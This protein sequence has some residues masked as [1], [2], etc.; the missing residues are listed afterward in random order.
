MNASSSILA[1]GQNGVD[2]TGGSGGS[3]GGGGGQFSGGSGGSGDNG[4]TGTGSPVTSPGLGWGQFVTAGFAWPFGGDGGAATDPSGGS[5]GDGAPGYGGGG[6]GNADAIGNVGAGG[7]GLICIVCRD[8]SGSGQLYA[9]GG[10]AESGVGGGGGG[11]SIYVAAQKYTG[12][13]TALVNGGAGGAF[14]GSNG[15]ARIYEIGADGVTL[16]L[17]AFNQSWDNT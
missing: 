9:F 12:T 7:G 17:R 4:N 3:G 8:L 14:G 6:G 15:T 1:N 10:E 16:T 5:G 13:I 2:E 11:G